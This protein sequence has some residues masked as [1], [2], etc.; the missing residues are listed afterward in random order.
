M[1]FIFNAAVSR[2]AVNWVSGLIMLTCFGENSR[3]LQ[4]RI[5]GLRQCGVPAWLRLRMGGPC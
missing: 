3:T 2:S 4:S 5:P 1:L